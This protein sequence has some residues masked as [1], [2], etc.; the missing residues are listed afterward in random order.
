MIQ[1]KSGTFVAVDTIVF[2]EDAAC[3][4]VDALFFDC[5]GDDNPDLYVVSGAMNIQ[6]IIFPWQIDYILIMGKDTCLLLQQIS[7]VARK[8]L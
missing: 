5:N 3:E 8:V 4:D 2:N 1:Q 6:A 7:L